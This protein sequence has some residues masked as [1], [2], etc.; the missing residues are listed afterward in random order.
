[1]IRKTR[2][3]SKLMTSQ[4][5]KQIIAIPI[6]LHISRSKGNRANKFGLPTEYKMRN[7]FLEK[8][9]TKFGGETILDPFPKNQN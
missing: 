4:P 1:M 8:L 6:A 2:L 5:W 9:F 3:V 7:I